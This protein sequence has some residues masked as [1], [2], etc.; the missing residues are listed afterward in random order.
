MIDYFESGLSVN[1]G[2]Y[3]VPQEDLQIYLQKVFRDQIP[4]MQDRRSYGGP[5]FGADSYSESSD[6][7]GDGI[8]RKWRKNGGGQGMIRSV[9]SAFKSML[10]SRTNQEKVKEE[11]PQ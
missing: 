5:Q 8:D 10:F 3:K 2:V 6:A 11:L 7:D 4:L 9:G 1:R